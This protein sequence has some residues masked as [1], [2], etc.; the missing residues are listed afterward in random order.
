MAVRILILL[1]LITSVCSGQLYRKR[2][3]DYGVLRYQEAIK[4][5]T[6]EVA[7]NY[8]VNA[9]ADSSTA[10]YWPDTTVALTNVKAL[11]N[12]R[13]DSSTALYWPDTTV[14]LTY[15]KAL[16][17]ARADSATALYWADTT[18]AGGI[19]TNADVIASKVGHL[20]GY[21]FVSK[22]FTNVGS[23][24]TDVYVTAFDAEDMMI[25]D[26]RN[27]D[28]VRA[29]FMVDYVGSLTD[30]TRWVDVADNANILLQSGQFSADQDAG[31]VPTTGWSVLPAAFVNASKTIEQ[32][33]ISATST[34]DPTYRGY[35]LYG[36]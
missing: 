29:V 36:K 3:G 18:L 12:A 31:S 11:I 20:L 14:A 30:T 16:I 35:A 25:I 34:N 8:D 28:S 6:A 21:V 22:A 7:T 10:L 32:Q 23:T 9:R 5:D 26:F 15:S 4:V 24:W 17:N 19:A 33:A 13:A 1:L 2:V 27:V